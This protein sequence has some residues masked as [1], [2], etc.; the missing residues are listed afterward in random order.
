MKSIYSIHVRRQCL[1]V[2]LPGLIFC[3]NLSCK[4]KDFFEAYRNNEIKATIV[5]R[6]GATV[7]FEAKGLDAQLGC[8]TITGSSYGEG[9]NDLSQ[10]VG[11][12]LEYKCVTSPGTYGSAYFRYQPSLNSQSYYENGFF[13]NQASVT[14]QNTVTFTV[15]K[16][17]YWEGY[18]KGECWWNKD[19]VVING[20]FKGERH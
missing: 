18:F 13:P 5:H 10:R 17:H 3:F 11:F 20:T 7:T 6:S 16:D 12:T 8:A 2:I 14:T 15:V 9:N 4:K 1:A 19:T